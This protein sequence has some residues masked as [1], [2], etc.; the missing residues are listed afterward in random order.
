MRKP[1]IGLAIAGGIKDACQ[2]ILVDNRNA[3]VRAER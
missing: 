3:F 2:V 1:V